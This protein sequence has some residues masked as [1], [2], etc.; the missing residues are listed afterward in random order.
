MAS[1]FFRSRELWPF[2]ALGFALWFFFLATRNS[3]DLDLWGLLSFG[4]LFRQTFPRF[5]THDVFSYTAPGAPWIYHE[6]LS[7]VLFHALFDSFGSGSLFV[8]KI[9]LVTGIFRL[10]YLTLAMQARNYP[11]EGPTLLLMA[12]FGTALYLFLPSVLSTLR[13]HTFTFLGFALLLWSLE[14]LRLQNETRPLRWFPLAFLLWGNLHGGYVVAFPALAVYG[15]WFL[16]ENRR[17][18]FKAVAASTGLC[19]LAAFINPYGYRLPLELASAW[20]HPRPHIT[21]WGNVIRWS[22]QYGL[23]ASGL[24]A[25]WLGLGLWSWW[26]DRRA[27]PAVPIL[28]ALFGVEGWLHMKLLP[29][30]LIAAMSLGPALPLQN[31]PLSVK[32]VLLKVLGW[33]CMPLTLGAVAMQLWYLAL[34]GL[35]VEV[36][37]ASARGATFHYPQGAAAFI[38]ANHIRGNL[39]STFEW[40]EYLMWTLHPDIRV[41]LDGRYETLY[42]ETVFRHHQAFFQSPYRVENAFHYPTQLVLVPVTR[43]PVVERLLRDARLHPLYMDDVAVLFSTRKGD[44]VFTAPYPNPDATLD[45]YRH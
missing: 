1:T 15:L 18:A 2:Y 5:P 17:E 8:L 32:P 45:D 7:G 38:K 37:G 36:P 39:W 6:W 31:L 28:L 35:A 4:E 25:L 43:R 19:L 21:E 10:V 44:P 12:T 29:L 3:V 11:G 33:I 40:G 9:I 23:W 27:F 41:S 34:A 26:R 14:K 30:F 13:C 22:F 16:S 24:I 42:P 20:F